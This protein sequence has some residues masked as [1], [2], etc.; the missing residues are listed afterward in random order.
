MTTT[1]RPA[2]LYRLRDAAGELMY[3]GIA[4]NPGRRFQQHATG[5][6]WWGDVARI[7]LEHYATRDEALRAERSAITSERPPYN[8]QPVR[9][10]DGPRRPGTIPNTDKWQHLDR[11]TNGH[12]ADVIRQHRADGTSFDAIAL[13]L[14]SDHGI[15]VT[16]RTVRN[17]V[18][19]MD[20]VA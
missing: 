19:E 14:F 20:G 11:L 4:G 13:A 12:A 17:W 15:T 2:S 10:V 5:K 16:G 6:A 18:N 1:A 3:V 8:N 7:D 9:P